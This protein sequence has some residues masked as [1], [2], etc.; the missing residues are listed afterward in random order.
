MKN[1]LTT[2]ALSLTLAVAAH[3]V[4]FQNG[5]FEVNAGDITGV[6]T[7]AGWTITNGPP[8]RFLNDQGATDGAFAALFN[9]GSGQNGSVLSQTFDTL[10]G[11]LYTVTFD[12]G[13]HGSDANQRLKIEVRD[14]I[15]GDELITVGSGAVNTVS[16]GAGVVIEQNTNVFIFRDSTGSSLTVVAPAPNIKFSAFS[17]TFKAQSAS[18]TLS[19][20]DQGSGDLP[21]SDGILDNVRVVPVRPS[22]SIRV[23]QLELCWDSTPTNSYQLQY[24]SS[25]TTNQWVNF[26][27]LIVGDGSRRCASDFVPQGEP[28]RYYQLVITP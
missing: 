13:T 14:T 25:L 12:W 8:V 18:A 7:A 6:M 11:Q 28:E 21:S 5:S 3:A 15:T 1:T 2:I 26:G 4:P 17:F 27:S 10:A 19:F 20:T 24:R 23:S 16:G 9:P 22:L